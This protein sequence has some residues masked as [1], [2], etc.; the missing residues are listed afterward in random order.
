MKFFDWFRSTRK[1]TPPTGEGA[2]PVADLLRRLVLRTRM[3]SRQKLLGGY[4]SSFRGNGMQFREVREYQPGDDIRFIEWNASARSGGTHTYTKVFQEERELT[5]YLILDHSPSMHAGWQQGVAR[6]S[7]ETLAMLG[8]SVSGAGDKLGLMVFAEQLLYHSPPR[9]GTAHL[10]SLLKAVQSLPVP[11]SGGTSVKMVLNKI[12]SVVPHKSVIILIS[13]FADDGYG[14]LLRRVAARHDCIGIQLLRPLPRF[15]HWDWLPVADAETGNE[16][17]IWLGKAANR[18]ALEMQH[19][20]LTEEAALLF[21]QAHT[22]LLLLTPETDALQ[23]L[24][25][26]FHRRVLGAHA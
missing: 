7:L 23:V 26:F 5:V 6:Q 4:R 3:E 16:R 25:S 15:P 2:L 19:Q 11:T 24:G 13:D 10:Y 1:T 21:Q 22:D 9:K 12:L 8:A 18:R 20:R 17:M 14:P